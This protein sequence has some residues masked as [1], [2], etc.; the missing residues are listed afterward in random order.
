MKKQDSINETDLINAISEIANILFSLHGNTVISLRM[1]KS[2][3][4]S[5]CRRG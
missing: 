3:Q 5:P 2:Y 1:E 4:G